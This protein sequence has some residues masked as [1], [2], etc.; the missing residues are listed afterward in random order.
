M[1]LPLTDNEGLY[2]LS[3]LSAE[4]FITSRFRCIFRQRDNISNGIWFLQC[5]PKLL[6]LSMSKSQRRDVY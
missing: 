4:S 6:P 5:S 2:S 3:L 1:V